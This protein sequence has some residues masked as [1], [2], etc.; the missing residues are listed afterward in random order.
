MDTA[1]NVWMSADDDQAQA[2]VPGAASPVVELTPK[3]EQACPVDSTPARML[4]QD[5]RFYVRNL[6]ALLFRES[7][8]WIQDPGSGSVDP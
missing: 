8:G 7:G 1:T 6:V 3:A 4:Y 5:T 2:T